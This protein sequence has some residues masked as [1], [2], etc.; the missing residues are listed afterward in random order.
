MCRSC[1]PV[2]GGFFGRV[3][4]GDRVGSKWVYSSPFVFGESKIS[5][6]ESDRVS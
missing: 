2:W 3:I 4:E 6:R 5:S 1:E